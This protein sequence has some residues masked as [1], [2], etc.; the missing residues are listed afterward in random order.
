MEYST[1]TLRG[2][3]RMMCIRTAASN[4]RIEEENN[5]HQHYYHHHPA[6]FPATEESHFSVLTLRADT[7]PNV[8]VTCASASV[9][10]AL[11][12]KV[13]CWPRRTT[14][15]LTGILL[16]LGQLN[17]LMACLADSASSPLGESR[18]L[19]LRRVIGVCGRQHK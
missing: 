12:S 10:T 4:S 19:P 17:C 1:H 3:T 18:Y 13:H 11:L 2:G 9:A 6:D 16:L 8:P 7:A 15:S 14:L 5:H